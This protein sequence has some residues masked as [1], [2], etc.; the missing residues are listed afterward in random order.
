MRSGLE[1]KITIAQYPVKTNIPF[2]AS[3]GFHVMAIECARNLCGFD[4]ANSTEF[5]D[6]NAHPVIH[7]MEDQRY[8][9]F[10]GASMRLGAYQCKLEE[11]SLAI[12]SY[13]TEVIS[14][15][16][17]HRYEFNNEY[18]DAIRN[19]GFKL[20]GVSMNDLL[21]E[22]IEYP[23][24]DYYIGVQFHPEFKSRPNRPHP[25]F[26]KLIQASLKV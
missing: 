23:H 25:L 7:L 22:V 9:D 10:V 3:S 21:V 11:D 6:M 17:R 8:I 12:Q 24:N 4:D 19:A 20:S 26:T 15:R 13:G 5:D 18:R 2:L 14:E 16:H 1:G